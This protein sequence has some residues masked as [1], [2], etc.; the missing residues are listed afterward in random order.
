MQKNIP[1]NQLDR[2]VAQNEIVKGIALNFNTLQAN[3]VDV[4]A[5]ADYN[6]V[7][8]DIYLERA[9]HRPEYIFNGYLEDLI[10]AMYA[11]TPSFELWKKPYGTTHK[12][13]IDFG[14][15]IALYGEDKL[16]VELRA[17]NTAFTSLS[18]AN[19]GVQIETVPSA[20]APSPIYAVDAI[21]VPAGETNLTIKL[22]DNVVKVVAITD[23]ASD[24]F[25]SDE[26]K[27]DGV[28]ISAEGGYVKNVTQ[29]LLEI[30]NIGYF[31]NNPES[32]IEDL[33]LFAGETPIHG[34][35][36]RGKLDKA[37]QADSKIMVVRR[38]SI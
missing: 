5:L 8:V 4:A 35:M 29:T 14:G 24:Y 2:L 30:E 6:R 36:L 25:A 28:E 31:N 17:Q 15:T 11:Q 27:F 7:S 12:V 3:G 1:F 19:S 22:G 32:A 9:G 23:R 16:V 26:A 20:D 34:A 18:V 37:A 10:L 21:G 13:L 33:V 38:V